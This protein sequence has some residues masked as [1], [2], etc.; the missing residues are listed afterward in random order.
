[1]KKIDPA[2]LDISRVSVLIPLVMNS[3]YNETSFQTVNLKEIRDA[4]RLK[5]IQ[6]KA[7]LLENLLQ[8]HNNK[9]SRILVIGSWLGFTSLCLS[10][11]GYKNITEVDIDPRLEHF[12]RHLNRDNPHFVHLSQDINDVSMKDY[13]VIINTSCEHILENSWFDRIQHNQLILL[14]SNNLS[15]YDHVNTCDSLQNMIDKYPM[16]LLYS[17]EL[18]FGNW[19]RYM[20]I[21]KKS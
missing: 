10:H 15:G 4:F 11:C 13:D 8:H 17:G 7:W 2:T 16:N 19:N 21:G 18:D 1:M 14:H 5:Q 6:S 12:A 20:L 3:L 9:D